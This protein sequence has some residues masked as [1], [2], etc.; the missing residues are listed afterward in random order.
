[1]SVRRTTSLVIKALFDT[2]GDIRG[3]TFLE[4]FAGSGNVGMEALKRGAKEV[5]FVEINPHIVREL[6]K[7]VARDCIL[8]MD[9]KK[10]VKK[11]YLEGKMFD[12]IF[13]DPPYEMGFVD[14]L[15]QLLEEV[16]LLKKN[17]ILVIERSIRESLELRSWNLLKER[18]YGDTL[19][20]YLY[21]GCEG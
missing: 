18:R 4:L 15:L 7:K 11:L 19:L 17:G 6:S 1:M 3:K 14:E 2:L 9:Y 5:F 8:C 21:R 10:A 12:I 20:S 13:A 16:P